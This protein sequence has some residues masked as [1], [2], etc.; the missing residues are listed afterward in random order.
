[1]ALSSSP[2]PHAPAALPNNL[3]VMLSS[4]VG[5]ER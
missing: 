2:A 5:R 4:F 1:M 3:P